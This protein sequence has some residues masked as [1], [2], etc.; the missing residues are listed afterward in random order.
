MTNKTIV[1]EYVDE[2]SYYIPKHQANKVAEAINIH[3][4]GTNSIN[5]VTKNGCI[6]GNP[7]VSKHPN[8]EVLVEAHYRMSAVSLILVRIRIYSDGTIDMIPMEKP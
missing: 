3:L 7:K 2:I 4:V 5:T 6:K 8:Y 1:Y